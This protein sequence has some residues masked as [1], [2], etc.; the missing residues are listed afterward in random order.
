MTGQAASA[1]RK[2][3]I[4]VSTFGLQMGSTLSSDD[5]VDLCVALWGIERA[6]SSGVPRVQHTQGMLVQKR[7]QV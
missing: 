3:M 1:Y 7:R 2:S 5:V 4:R 6:S